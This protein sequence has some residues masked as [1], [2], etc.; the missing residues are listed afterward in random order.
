MAVLLSFE[1]HWLYSTKKRGIHHQIFLHF[2]YFTISLKSVHEKVFS[3][4]LSF[5]PTPYFK[6]E[7]RN[8]VI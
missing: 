7:F 4:M 2:S 3:H 5:H 6:K 1:D 8:D